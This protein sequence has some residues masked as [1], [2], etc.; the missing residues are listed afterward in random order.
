LYEFHGLDVVGK[1]GELAGSAWN[2]FGDG[3]AVDGAAAAGLADVAADLQDF[4][5]DEQGVAR[6]T[7]LRNFT[8]S[9]L[10][11]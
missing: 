2:G 4:G 3:F 5:L 1:R 6:Q 8:L 9:A 11:K 10:M 7:G